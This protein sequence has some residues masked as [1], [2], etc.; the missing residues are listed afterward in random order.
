MPAAAADLGLERDPGLGDAV[1][2]R[3]RLGEVEAVGARLPGRV[4]DQVGDALAPLHGLEVPREGDEVAPVA[5]GGEERRGRRCVVVGER[6]LERA[7]PALDLLRRAGL[8]GDGGLGHGLL[9]LVTTT[10]PRGLCPHPARPPRSVHAARVRRDDR[11][12]CGRR[13]VRRRARRGRGGA[14][15]CGRADRPRPGDR[16]R[17]GTQLHLCG[18]RRRGARRGK[19][20]VLVRAQARHDPDA[21]DG[22]GPQLAAGGRPR[23]A[24][25]VTLSGGARHRILYMDT[26]D[27]G[28]LF[29]TSHCQNQ[30]TPRLV[31]EN[32]A[33]ADGN[34]TGEDFDGGG[35]GAIFARGGRLRIAHST[36]V[37]N[38]CDSTGPDVGGGAVRALSEY[39]GAPVDVV[40]SRFTANVC[41]NG[42]ALP[43]SGCRG[44][45]RTA[46]S[47]AI[48]QSERRNPARPGTPGGGSG[49]AIY[50]DGNR[51]A[52]SG[53]QQPPGGQPRQRGRWGDLLRQQRS[54]RHARDQGQRPA[55]QSQRRLSDRR[56]ARHLLPG[57]RAASDSALRSALTRNWT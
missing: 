42:G 23:R 31:V 36:F 13:G 10:G 26:C 56:P 44:A 7:E 22:E 9:L 37:H 49:G 27:P 33:F 51:F 30:A 18:R 43:A 21:R 32:L 24:G 35:G 47:S 39:G 38:R 12:F 52:L 46:G 45:S 8:R 3:G 48:A 50:N 4:L 57:G 11:S 29:T 54:H 28:R 20:Q 55:A 16:A 14:V 5:V 2:L 53:L 34:S 41:S 1:G 40:S 19:D 15:G 6:R 17:H 25:M